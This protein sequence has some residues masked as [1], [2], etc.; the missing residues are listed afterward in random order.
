MPKIVCAVLAVLFSAW[1]SFA[2]DTQKP[3]LSGSIL[4]STGAA[5][6]GFTLSID[7]KYVGF[8]DINGEFNIEAPPSRFVVTSNEADPENFRVFLDFES[9]SMIPGFLRLQVRGP[10]KCSSHSDFGSD[11]IILKSVQPVY[12]PAARAVHAVGGVSVQQKVD[13]GGTVISTHTLAGHPLLKS[14]SEIA[15]KSMLFGPS[16]HPERTV[17]MT[18]VYLLPAKKKE[19]LTRYSCPYR[20]IVEPPPDVILNYTSI[21]RTSLHPQAFSSPPLDPPSSDPSLLDT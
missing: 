17:V 7:G 10:L 9:D 8:T 12:P 4:D 19:G 14:V 5:V 18:Y 1:S 21:R 11:P 16:Q 13:S 6:P 20:Q 2:Q 15:A 3:I